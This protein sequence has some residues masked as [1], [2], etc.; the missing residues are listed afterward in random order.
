MATFLTVVPARTPFSERVLQYLLD[1]IF[2]RNEDEE[3]SP[4][5]NQ[6]P[7]ESLGLTQ[8]L[9]ENLIE[10]ETVEDLIERGL[11]GENEDGKLRLQLIWESW[12]GKQVVL[13]AGTVAL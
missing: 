6:Q 11:L 10:Y 12:R 8:Q 13:F 2:G 4:P 9:G 5:T 3:P 1:G 7:Q